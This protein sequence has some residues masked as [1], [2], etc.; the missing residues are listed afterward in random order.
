MAH[1]V[2]VG[3]QSLGV[4]QA[5]HVPLPSQTLPPLVAQSVPAPRLVTSQHPLLQWFWAQSPWGAGQLLTAA[6]AM[7]EGPPPFTLPVVLPPPTP[8]PPVPLPLKSKPPRMLVH[9]PAPT[10][11]ITKANTGAERVLHGGSPL[12]AVAQAGRGG[13]LQ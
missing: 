12:R 3:G 4:L 7:H 2:P 1:A 5:T 11:T 8:A 13:L 6:Q 9:D 10:A